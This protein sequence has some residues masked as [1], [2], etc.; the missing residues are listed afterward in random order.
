MEVQKFETEIFGNLYSNHFHLQILLYHLFQK[1]KC[2]YI[3]FDWDL[4]IDDQRKDD[5]FYLNLI[6]IV[7]D[8]Q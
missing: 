2:I 3:L 7:V 4:C 6:H 5:Q 1:E 8:L